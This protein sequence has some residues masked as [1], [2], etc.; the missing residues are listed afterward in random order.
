[1]YFCW[2]YFGRGLQNSK[3]FCE[4]IQE[5]LSFSYAGPSWFRVTVST[6]SFQE[7][8]IKEYGLMVIGILAMV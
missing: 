5:E 7:S 4:G 2:L 1:M 3:S 8:S 6:K